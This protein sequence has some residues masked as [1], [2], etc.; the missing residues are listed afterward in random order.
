MK[1]PKIRKLPSGSYYCE[2]KINKKRIYITEPTRLECRNK[3][4]LLKA[5]HKNGML[6]NSTDVTLRKAIDKYIDNRSNVLSPSTI[7]GYRTIQNN[8]FKNVMDRRIDSIDNWQP[9]I[10]TEAKTCSAKTLKNAWGFINS[11]LKENGVRTHTVTLPQIIYDESPFIQPDM[12]KPFMGA[13]RDDSCELFCLLALHGLRRSEIMALDVKRNI[14]DKYI[15]VQGATVPNE[16]HKLVWKKENKNSSSRR[17]IPLLIPRIKE[18]IDESPDKA[19]AM[20]RISPN[21]VYRHMRSVCET[22]NM[23]YIGLHALRH[24]FASLCYSL[25]IS[26]AETMRLG[27]WTDPAVMR[28]IYTHLSNL[29]NKES[30]KR[31]KEFF[32]QDKVI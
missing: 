32:V 25:K 3:A 20:L 30:E 26:E 1:L 29:E 11:V 21:T 31:L 16:Q 23:E 28:K 15:K 10:N 7:R 19:Q 6:R 22:A 8:R 17:T 9:I 2:L 4:M 14:S 5:E 18:I 27:G 24:S 13:I 12:I